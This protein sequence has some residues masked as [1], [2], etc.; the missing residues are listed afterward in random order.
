MSLSE[1]APT[2]DDFIDMALQVCIQQ[3]VAPWSLTM[4]ERVEWFDELQRILD[5]RAGA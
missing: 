2:T 3:D 5:E 1:R 4:G